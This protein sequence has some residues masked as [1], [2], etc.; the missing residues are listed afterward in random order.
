MA[1]V[2]TLCSWLSAL[3]RQCSV[4]AC[5]RSESVNAKLKQKE[6]WCSWIRRAQV[7]ITGPHTGSD[8]GAAP[9]RTAWQM[10]EILS[11]HSEYGNA[12]YFKLKITLLLHS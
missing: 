12:Q 2:R 1:M 5:S 4:R 9:C 11:C 10:R 7:Y 6:S 3:L 8:T